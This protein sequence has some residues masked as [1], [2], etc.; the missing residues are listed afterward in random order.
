[1]EMKKLKELLAINKSIIISIVVFFLAMSCQKDEINQDVILLKKYLNDYKKEKK[2]NNI[3]LGMDNSN[4]EIFKIYK[5]HLNQDSIKPNFNLNIYFLK[6]E[7]ND[8][9]NQIME[10]GK[11]D[12][13]FN[14]LDNVVPAEGNKEAEANEIVFVTKPIYVHSGNYALLYCYTKNNKGV[15][16]IPPIDVYKKI[17]D[18][19]EKDSEIKNF[20]F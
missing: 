11:W 12:I 13:N 18:S 17:N 4:K 19:W 20:G 15:F 16:F 7:F 8:F 1:M 5:R 10:N 14:K 3:Y 9:K 6:D 2:L